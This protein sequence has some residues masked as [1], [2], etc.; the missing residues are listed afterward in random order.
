[1]GK[2]WFIARKSLAGLFAL[3][4]M[5]GGAVSG[6]PSVVEGNAE[7]VKNRSYNLSDGVGF[8]QGLACDGTYFYGTGAVKVLNYNSIVKIDVETGDIVAVDETPLPEEMILKGYSHLGDCCLY[9]G[10]LYIACED[11]GFRNPAVA[12]YDAGT[13]DFLEYYTVPGEC[14]GNGRIPWCAVKDGVLYFSQSNDVDEIRKLDIANGFSYAGSIKLDRV[15]YKMQGGE[16]YDGKLYVTVNSEK[17]NKPVYAIDPSTGR[18]ETAFVRNTGRLDAEG[19]GIAIKEL[20]DG[21][22]FHIIDADSSV[23][24]RS[25]A[26]KR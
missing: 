21:S 3:I 24:I 7:L 20:D 10:R 16:F 19:E 4:A 2:I 26:I 1:M 25:Y 13:L 18:V 14:R 23:H 22:A 5:I 9:E 12:V 17:Y 11:Y 8:G 15:L 6:E